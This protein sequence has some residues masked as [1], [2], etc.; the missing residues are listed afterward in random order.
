MTPAATKAA[1]PDIV[2][3]ANA[4][5]KVKEVAKGS[6]KEA[7]KAPRTPTN[8]QGQRQGP[9]RR[10][11]RTALAAADQAKASGTTKKA[12]AKSTKAKTTTKKA[13]TTKESSHRQ[14]DRHQ[15]I[16]NE[17]INSQ[18]SSSETNR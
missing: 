6:D 2:L 11:R 5:G 7:K 4:D 10:G 8:Q 15:S 9:E 14:E 12:A 16:N 1:K 18:S 13:T 17:S 3:L